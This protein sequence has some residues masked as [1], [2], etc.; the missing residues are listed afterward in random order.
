MFTLV[1]G[2]S[3][4]GKSEFAERLIEKNSVNRNH[5]Y[6][7]AT[8]MPFGEEGRIRIEKHRNQRQNRNFKTIEQYL[9]LSDVEVEDGSD[10]L[11]ECMSNLVANEVFH[12]YGSHDGVCESIMQGVDHIRSVSANLVIV[13]NEVFSDGITYDD[14]TIRY[15]NYLGQ[16][17][18]RLAVLADNVIEVVYT[19]PVVQ[20]G[21]LI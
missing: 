16:I 21:K 11:L 14:E 10:V 12:E 6:Y 17:N 1:T 13:T 3:G 20:K 2:G 9:N 5:R 4:S 19:I 18:Q 8:M 15:L 7:I